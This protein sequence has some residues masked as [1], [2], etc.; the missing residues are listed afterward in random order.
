MLSLLRNSQNRRTTER[1]SCN[2]P[3]IFL[4]AFNKH[5]LR[6]HANDAFCEIVGSY[7]IN[8]QFNHDFIE[9]TSIRL[10]AFHRLREKGPEVMWDSETFTKC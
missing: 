10:L 5:R 4:K 8:G 6:T 2:N 3:I 7:L 9:T 1:N